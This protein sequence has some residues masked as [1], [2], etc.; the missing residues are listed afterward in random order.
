M[1]A[2]L[3]SVAFAAGGPGLPATVA[4]V[5]ALREARRAARAFRPPPK[6][7]VGFTDCNRQS[8]QTVDCRVTFTFGPPNRGV[9]T[10]T[11]R[12]QARPGGRPRARP[13]G[14]PRC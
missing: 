3:A 4:R 2:A 7:A 6:V 11:W 8:R 5:V 13:L 14:D 10:R 9:C 12:V 1:V